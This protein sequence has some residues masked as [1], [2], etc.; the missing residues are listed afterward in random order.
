M[1][2]GSPFSIRMSSKA[3]ERTFIPLLTRNLYDA[4]KRRPSTLPRVT[5][6]AVFF[7]SNSLIQLETSTCSCRLSRRRPALAPPSRQVR[8]G[9]LG[10]LRRCACSSVRQKSSWSESRLRLRTGSSLLKRAP[11]AELKR[12]RS[13]P[14]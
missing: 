9:R 4:S 11:F 8:L 1:Y 7:L 5:E 10:R 13:M 2:A 12:R 14:K 6:S 3:F